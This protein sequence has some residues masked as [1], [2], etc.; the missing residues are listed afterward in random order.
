MDAKQSVPSPDTTSAPSPIVMIRQNKATNQNFG[1]NGSVGN[2]LESSSSI[3]TATLAL[4]SGGIKS[5]LS[6]MLMLNKNPISIGTT[7]LTSPGVTSPTAIDREAHFQSLLSKFLS[8]SFD[9]YHFDLA[10]AVDAKKLQPNV[11]LNSEIVDMVRSK[12]ARGEETLKFLLPVINGFSKHRAWL[13]LCL[14]DMLSIGGGYAMRML[15]SKRDH[16]NKLVSRFPA[17]PPKRTDE[18]QTF[19]LYLMHKWKVTFWERSKE[20]GW[21]DDFEGIGAMHELLES[22]GKVM[23]FQNVN[24]ASVTFHKTRLFIPKH[25]TTRPGCHDLFLF[26]RRSNNYRRPGGILGDGK[27]DCQ[28]RAAVY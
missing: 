7:S 5:T 16:L 14:L 23:M 24:A 4:S 1:N 11:D 25:S 26:R 19:V 10:L 22:K 2:K 13:A 27:N 9:P 12:P 8:T 21:E 15:L 3:S 17:K 20:L 6:S 18:I 28:V